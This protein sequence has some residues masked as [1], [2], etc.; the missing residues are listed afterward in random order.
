[1]P[2][3]PSPKPKVL[4]PEPRTLN[5]A[6]Q[7]RLVIALTDFQHLQP[8]CVSAQATI[9]GWLGW[10]HANAQEKIHHSEETFDRVGFEAHIQRLLRRLNHRADAVVT[11]QHAL[12]DFLHFD[13]SAMRIFGSDQP[14]TGAVAQD[15]M[16]FFQEI[17]TTAFAEFFPLSDSPPTDLIHVTCTGYLSP[18][19]AQHLVEKRQWSTVT[20][21]TH[22]YHMG[23]YAAFPALRLAAGFLSRERFEG[24]SSAR[25][26]VVHTELCTL[27]LNPTLHSI[28]QL[29]IQSLF[30][31]GLIKYSAINLESETGVESPHL[32]V[33]AQHE[34]ILPDS[35]DAMTW[36]C[37]EWGMHMTLARTVP[38][39]IARALPAFLETLS[40]KAGFDAESLRT[41]ARFAIHPGG[42]KIVAE[43]Q[44]L[45]SLSEV[46]VAASKQVLAE[47]GNM[48]SATLPHIWERLLK[49][50]AIPSG[51]LI[52]SLAFGPGL[53]MC[54]SVMEKQAE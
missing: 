30:A 6:F 25:V 49:D 24:N 52:V 17:A 54:G 18:S 33:L 15:R 8:G 13:Q 50:D 14:P 1:M 35:A 48:S 37:S 32:T 2:Q 26:D 28:E 43:I 3:A 47:C 11:R 46:Q 9:T 23:C 51:T 45:L 44:S 7:T 27:H 19:S 5:P 20:R 21:V 53:T 40:R 39:L 16:A 12:K 10:A 29:V 38:E 41:S 36:V 34:Q 4:N 22:A 42:P 31:D